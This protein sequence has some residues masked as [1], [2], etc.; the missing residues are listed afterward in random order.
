MFFIIARSL[1]SAVPKYISYFLVF[2]STQQIIRQNSHVFKNNSKFLFSL[3]LVILEFNWMCHRE[4][5]G[6]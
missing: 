3:F 2:C 1:I 6:K 5:W 4:L